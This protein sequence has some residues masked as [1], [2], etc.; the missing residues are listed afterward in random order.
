MPAVPVDGGTAAGQQKQQHQP[1]Q[2]AAPGAGL[3]HI[4]RQKIRD[5]RRGRLRQ[6]QGKDRLDGFYVRP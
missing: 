3:L 6:L 5:G 2:P 1:E 4:V